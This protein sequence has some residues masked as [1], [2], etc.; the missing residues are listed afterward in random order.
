[1][2]LQSNLP[3]CKK[4]AQLR[5]SKGVSQASLAEAV[6]RSIMHIS[7]IERGEAECEG[8]MLE[9]IKKVLGIENAPLTELELKLYEDRLWVLYDYLN[10]NRVH[11]AR[12]MINEMADILELPFEK[13][14][15]FI[16][17]M[18]EFILCTKEYNDPAA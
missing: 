11:E 6:D 16:Y 9:I 13:N 5:K 2:E 1:M 8:E 17:L 3:L 7:R 10:A 12:K 15:S 18:M 14:L 4:I